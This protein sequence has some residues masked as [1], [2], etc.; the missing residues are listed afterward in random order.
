MVLR[1][2]YL[3]SGRGHLDKGLGHR[4]ETEWA[5]SRGGV[6][7]DVLGLQPLQQRQLLDHPVACYFRKKASL[8][9]CF[10]LKSLT[11]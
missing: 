2:L 7:L 9:L 8:L 3:A 1:P 11:L 6:A 4:D 5:W 10:C